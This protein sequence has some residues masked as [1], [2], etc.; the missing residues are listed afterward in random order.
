[1]NIISLY[2]NEFT[3]VGEG[4]RQQKSLAV[5]LRLT[6]H[7]Q[8]DVQHVNARTCTGAVHNDKNE[9]KSHVNQ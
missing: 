2:S 4:V 7:V 9:I 5:F 6:L 3:P 1:V 8:R